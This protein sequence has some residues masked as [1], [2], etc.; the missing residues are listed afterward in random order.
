MI[1]KIVEVMVVRS[2]LKRLSVV[3]LFQ[4]LYLLAVGIERLE[5]TFG[6]G[7]LALLILRQVKISLSIVQ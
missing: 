2:R 1:L 6:E 5:L 4:K 7:T 3:L